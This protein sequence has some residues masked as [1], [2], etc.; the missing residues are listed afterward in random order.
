VLGLRTKRISKSH[1]NTKAHTIIRPPSRLHGRNIP[2][3]PNPLIPRIRIHLLL[4]PRTQTTSFPSCVGELDPDEG[5]LCVAE[6][7]DAFEG[8]DLGVLP[9]AGVFGGDLEG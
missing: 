5:A 1:E 4:N 6:I 9:D 7:D 8:R 2:P 3:L